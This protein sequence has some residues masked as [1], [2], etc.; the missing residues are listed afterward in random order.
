[1]NEYDTDNREHLVSGV[2]ISSFI[3]EVFLQIQKISIENLS[4]GVSEVAD[5]KYDEDSFLGVLTIADPLFDIA[6]YPAYIWCPGGSK[7]WRHL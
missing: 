5:H 1:M 6:N 2:L 4:P 3:S 7:F